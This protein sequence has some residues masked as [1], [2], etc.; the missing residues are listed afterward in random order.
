M[1]HDALADRL[2]DTVVSGKSGIDIVMAA[3]RL[4]QGLGI[5]AGLGHAEAHMR[6]RGRGGIADE[7]SASK[8]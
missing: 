7:G 2:A 3:E 6:P 1:Q 4:R 5:A 8:H